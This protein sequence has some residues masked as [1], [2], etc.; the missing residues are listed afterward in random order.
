MPQPGSTSKLYTYA[1]YLTWTEPARC[2]LHDGVVVDMSAAPNLDHQEIVG[3]LYAQILGA[4]RGKPCRVFV[5]P[6]DVRL[7]KP[8]QTDETAT[9]VL[10][11]D[12]LVVCNR[13]QLDSRGV[14][15]PPDLVIE[16]LS[17][18]TAGRD[19]IAKR[20]F[21]ERSGVR[22]YWLVHPQD[23]IATIYV[24]ASGRF[25]EPNIVP[26]EGETAVSVLP[27]VAIQWDPISEAL[28]PVPP[29]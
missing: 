6:V 12:I 15:G 3:Q 19:H 14:K 8:G 1:D 26:F 18:S 2:E 25:G 21:Y 27:G 5:A 22:E 24:L 28:G 9:T 11:P 17:P 13:S 16:V 29:Y 23:R 20:R 7:P 10:Q 4:L